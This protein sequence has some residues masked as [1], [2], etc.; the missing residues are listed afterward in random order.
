MY[1]C[2]GLQK[3]LPVV[4]LKNAGKIKFEK[5]WNV[6]EDRVDDNRRGKVARVVFIP[7]KK[8]GQKLLEYQFLLIF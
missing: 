8:N 7:N 3:V 6:I 2:K 4:K 5:L 1:F